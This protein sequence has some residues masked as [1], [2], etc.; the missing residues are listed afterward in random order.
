MRFHVASLP[1]T[2]TTRAYD[3]CAYTAKVRRFCDMLRSKGHEVI[4]YAGTE[5][6]AK[7]DELVTCAT[8]DDLTRWFGA[9]E[10]PVQEVFSHWNTEHPCWTEFNAN[11]VREIRARLQPLDVVCMIAGLCQRPLYDEF[12]V[13]NPVVEWGI[14]Y[15]GTVADF[16]VFESW[17][18]RHHVAGLDRDDNL[19][20]YDTVI[21]NSYHTVEL[22]DQ[23]ERPAGYLLYLGRPT[24]RKGLNIIRELAK[25]SPHSQFITAGQGEPWLEGAYHAGVVLGPMKNLL[26][27]NARAV[28]VPSTYLEPFGGVHAE[29]QLLG[30]PVITTDWG[31]F[32]ETVIDGST[33]YR[34]STLYDFLNAIKEVHRLD[35]AYIARRARSKWSTTVVSG[36]YD[37]YFDRV[38]DLY[39][40]GSW[41]QYVGP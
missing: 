30:V 6:E 31:C 24:E 10:W 8:A 11:V 17:A 23:S 40:G 21:P 9:P 33:G 27:A 22:G 15:S 37:T 3:W 26:I 39:R 12:R 38:V 2:Q 41:S 5:N 35:R 32:T 4:L 20:Y 29:A 14:G 13:T 16:R 36:T 25:A 34:C 19:R 28:L 18:W 1:H 7:V